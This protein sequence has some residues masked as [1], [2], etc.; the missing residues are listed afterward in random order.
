MAAQGHQQLPD[1]DGWT[2]IRDYTYQT[3]PNEKRDVGATA[4][5]ANDTWTVIIYDMAQAVGEK[6][7][8]QVALIF[9]PKGYERETFA[10]KTAKKLGAKEI[11]ALSAFVETGQQ[12]AR[13]PGVALGLV[14]DAKDVAAQAKSFYEQLAAERKLL[15]IPAVAADAAKLAPHYVNEALGDIT[16]SHNGAATVFDFGEWHSEVATRHNP[17][18]SVSFITTAPGISGFEFV[19]GSGAKPSLIVRDAQ[20]EY[21]FSADGSTPSSK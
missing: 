1:K 10:G 5:R 4:R 15:T 3:S 6:R 21:V 11:A 17:D 14:Q 16:V 12:K 7:G 8:A 19:V 18:G 13:V 9:G 2:N 20:H